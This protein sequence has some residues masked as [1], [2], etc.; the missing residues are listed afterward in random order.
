MQFYCETAGDR[1]EAPFFCFFVVVNFLSKTFNQGELLKA[2]PPLNKKAFL[3]KTFKQ[4]PSKKKNSN[5]DR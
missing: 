3:K 2:K 4:K 1:E 5:S